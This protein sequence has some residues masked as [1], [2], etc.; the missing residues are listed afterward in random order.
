LKIQTEAYP[1]L[2][3]DP[4]GE[5]V[6]LFLSQVGEVYQSFK[7][8]DSGCISYRVRSGDRDWFVKYGEDS[9]SITG[10]QRASKLN[11][12]VQHPALP[13][14][15]RTLHFPNGIALIFDWVPGEVLYGSSRFR[16]S[17]GNVEPE[18][19][20]QRFQALPPQ[21]IITGLSVIYD[22]HK[23]LAAHGYIAVDFYDGSILYDFDHSD[24]YLIDLDE[25]RFGPFQLTDERNPGSRRFMAP[26]E[27]QRGALIDQST[28]VFSLGRAASVFLGAGELSAATWRGNPALLPLIV[29]A[30]QTRKEDRFSSVDEFVDT[31]QAV[32]LQGG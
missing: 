10:L 12:T 31:W 28:N 20:R 21:E 2:Q 19:S 25:Y 32:L 1:I 5:S 26:E 30:T 29:R 17:P 15:R 9:R 23:K 4:I 3:K 6:E 7:H 11:L 8:Q 24:I 14:L 27:W 22:V 13:P 16:E 18:S